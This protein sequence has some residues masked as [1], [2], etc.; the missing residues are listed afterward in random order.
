MLVIEVVMRGGRPCA[1]VLAIALLAA[2]PGCGPSWP[3][4][5]PVTGKVVRANGKP[6]GVGTIIFTSVAD[7][8]ISADG[9]LQSDGTFTL[10]TKLHGSERKGAVEG[11]HYVRVDYPALNVGPDGQFQANPVAVTKTYKVEPKDNQ[12]TIEIEL[13]GKSR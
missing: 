4:L 5:Y 9:G 8:T 6:A 13:P 7:D 3:K 1:A 12:L 10:S 2:S 11:E